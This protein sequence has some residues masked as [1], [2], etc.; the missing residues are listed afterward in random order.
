M[1]EN[2]CE[3][4]GPYSSN[5]SVCPFC[6]GAYKQP[7]VLDLPANEKNKNEEGD[8][9][10]YNSEQSSQDEKNEYRIP[11]IRT[12]IAGRE[13]VKSVF[14]RILN[15]ALVF[16]GLEETCIRIVTINQDLLGILWVTAGPQRGRIYRIR[17][18][19]VAGLS[20]G[21]IIFDDQAVSL[22]Q[23]KFTVENNRI[24]VWDFGSHSGTFVN[25]NRIRSATELSENDTVN[26]GGTSF[27]LKLLL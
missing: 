13:S 8:H 9:K 14:L 3:L 11:S 1:G 16:I 19:T 10:I 20:Q 15:R 7:Q 21:N 25:G 12:S 6:A 27:I 18:G 17:D 24:V 4:H 26:I 22:P 23:A 2:F 5:Q